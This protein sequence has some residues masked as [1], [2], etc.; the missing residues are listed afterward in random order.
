MKLSRRTFNILLAI[1][2][3]MLIVWVTRAFTFFQQLQ[4]GTLVAP[5]VHFSLVVFGLAIGFYLTYLGIKGRRATR[6]SA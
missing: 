5:G 4:A 6:G 2:V 1:G 3:Y